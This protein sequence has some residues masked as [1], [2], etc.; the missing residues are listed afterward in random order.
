MRRAE[1]RV[2]YQSEGAAGRAAAQSDSGP[3]ADLISTYRRACWEGLPNMIHMCYILSEPLAG[4]VVRSRES[5][6]AG[7]GLC[8]RVSIMAMC[9][10]SWRA[11]LPCN[12]LPD[13]S[14]YSANWK[15]G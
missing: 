10:D 5:T 11:L 6:E 12:D 14:V 9:E 2:K 7:R 4:F 15:L 8:V 1:G 3:A 13:L